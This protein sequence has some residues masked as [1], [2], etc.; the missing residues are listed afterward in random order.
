MA[1]FV[2]FIFYSTYK[3]KHKKVVHADLTA[4]LAQAEQASQI[5][6]QQSLKSLG[7]D[8]FQNYQKDWSAYNLASMQAYMS[9]EY[10][11]KNVL[12]I[13]ALQELRR[14]NTT[15][16]K[17]FSDIFVADFSEDQKTCRIGMTVSVQ[18]QL[19]DTH[20]ER[21]LFELPLT[22]TEYYR[23]TH[24]GSRWIFTGIDQS[25]AEP[26]TQVAQLQ[27]F[28]SEN[29]YFYSLDWGWL[30]IPSKG[31]LFSQAKFGK[32]DIN[33]HLIGQHNDMLVQLYTYNPHPNIAESYL[34]AQVA[35]PKS[36]GDI[37][38]RRKNSWVRP[39]V[40]GLTEVT[41]EWPQF[42]EKYEVYASDLER[43]TSF[44]LLHPAFM[45]KLEAL[46]IEINIEVVDN[47]V[48]LYN[49]SQVRDETAY[50]IILGVLQEA[51]KQMRL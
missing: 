6:N 14:K 10:Y 20:E 37:V 8:T 3:Q 12:L 33:N 23:F 26:S 30:L 49:K 1:V 44:E 5:W 51:F 43:V 13:M 7:Q 36:Y 17:S 18:D 11:A 39:S 22:V 29:G 16:I 46:P 35:L 9:P 34:V 4:S 50:P 28:A 47:T 41:L 19:I 25:T 42:H 31:Q 40:K 38:V 15:V 24:D 21:T 32:S 27:Q 45:E 48:Y 2:A